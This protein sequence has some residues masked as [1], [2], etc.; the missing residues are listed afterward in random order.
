MWDCGGARAG[1][2]EISVRLTFDEFDL[3]VVSSLDLDGVHDALLQDPDAG[4]DALGDGGL[5]GAKGKVAHA[6]GALHP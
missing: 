5:V 3:V 1:G 6:E 2:Q 4:L